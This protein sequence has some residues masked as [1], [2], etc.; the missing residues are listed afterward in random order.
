MGTRGAW[1]RDFLVA[2]GNSNP[3]VKTINLVSAWTKAEGTAAT[4][5]PLA[6]TYNNGDNTRFNSA[7]V[8][9]YK[10]RVDGINATIKTLQGNWPGYR[11]IFVGLQTND[12]ERAL[13]GMKSSPWGTNFHTVETFWRKSDVTGETLRSE[14]PQK[15]ITDPREKPSTPSNNSYT[16]LVDASDVQ[17]TVSLG[18]ALV[19]ASIGIGII[20]ISAVK[21]DNVQTALK[22]AKVAI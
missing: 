13:S 4:Y 18:I 7:G 12:G 15:T 19:A 5:N 17:N 16:P 20:I 1:S 22:I 6:T 21:S 14:E 10:T 9:N 2:L 3:D 8:R 11:D